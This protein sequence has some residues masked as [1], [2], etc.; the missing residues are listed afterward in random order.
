MKKKKKIMLLPYLLILPIII[1]LSIF[2]IYPFVKTLVSSFPITT[3]IGE[4]LGWA[5][6]DNWKMILSDSELGRIMAI[7]FEFAGLH[8]VMVFF[9]AM[10]LALLADGITKKGKRL[11]QTMYALPLAIASSPA[12]LIW[13]FV[14]RKD[15]G[16]L[17][18]LLGTNVAWLQDSSK[19]LIFVAVVTAWSHIASSFILLLAGFKNVPEELLEAATLDGANSFRKITKIK[20]PLASS[21]IFFVLFLNIV[22]SFKTFGQIRLLT[23]GGPAGS[24]TTLM[25]QIYERGS[26]SGFFEIA[27]CYSV[28]LFLTIFIMTR[29]QFLFEKKFVHYQ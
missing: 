19:A 14:L 23:A 20:I 21:Q 12:S 29:I 1:L 3:P 5:G 6:L 15:G 25:Y 4:W 8:L 22:Q 7:T 13:R 27:C 18:E 24:T 26:E 16:V 10:V 17:N 28:V 11:I 2:K 9:S